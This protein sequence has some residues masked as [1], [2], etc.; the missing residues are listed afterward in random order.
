[1]I[2]TFLKDFSHSVFLSGRFMR[3]LYCFVKEIDKH[4]ISSDLDV[5]GRFRI[6]IDSLNITEKEPLN[7]QGFF[8][9][10]KKFSIAH[11]ITPKRVEV[12]QMSVEVPYQI[13]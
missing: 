5:D 13:H 10:I 3:T 7:Y 6:L 4:R 2:P 8:N 12:P 11:K 9:K 1:M